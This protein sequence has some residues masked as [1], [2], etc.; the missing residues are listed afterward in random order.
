MYQTGT[1]TR[2][3]KA[4]LFLLSSFAVFCAAP[5]VF[6][7]GSDGL[8]G[9]YQDIETVEVVGQVIASSNSYT[10]T[11]I[12]FEA[13][14]SGL[15]PVAVLPELLALAP[16]ANVRTNSRGEALVSFRGAGERQFAAF[17]NGVP[18]NVPWD[19][20][21]DLRLVPLV[22]VGRTS[23]TSGPAVARL[24][25]G[26]AGGVV[27][28]QPDTRDGV[29]L[30]VEAGSG[31][32]QR[33][34][35]S[36]RGSTDASSLLL[37]VGH[38][39]RAGL[40]AES[41]SR[42]VFAAPE[43]DLITNT[44]RR[45]SNILAHVKTELSGGDTLSATLLY[46]DAVYGVA[47]EQGA[48]FTASDT[49]YWRYPKS[50]YLLASVKAEI[51]FGAKTFGEFVAW[52]Q[53][54]NQ[55]IQSFT[56]SAYRVL[57]DVQ[58]DRNNSYGVRANFRNETS[59]GVF[60][61]SGSAL[62]SR[63]REAGRPSSNSIT[64]DDIFSHTQY[65]AALDYEGQL[66]DVLTLNLGAGYDVLNP[67]ETAGRISA[68][69][70]SGVNAVAELNWAPAGGWLFRASAGRRVRLPTMREL[71]GDAIGRFLL[72][73]DLSPEQTWQ[74][75]LAA[76]WQSESASFQIVPFA[77]FTHGTLDQRRIN[78]DGQLLRQRF[79]LRGHQTFGVEAQ[80]NMQLH[81][82]LQLNGHLTWN[83]HHVLREN[84][85]NS[86]RR[87]YLSDRPNW[88]ARANAAYQLGAKTT[89]GLTVVYRG[90]AR[91]QD[92]SGNFRRVSDATQL[93]LALSHQLVEDEDGLRVALYARADNLTDAFIEPQLGLPERG[94][95][96]LF[97]LTANL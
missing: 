49:R 88:L 41:D 4:G 91:S 34:E 78:V 77:S 53:S 55:D 20:R 8:S 1:I 40:P 46:N 36:Y 38:S 79:N 75:D 73:P 14:S 66:S 47:P 61:L 51:E 2:H 37:A 26:T 95:S 69:Q 93:N 15:T 90:E 7:A 29:A 5:A 62:S 82:K 32:L 50:E 94:R 16:S 48:G 60:T 45:Q 96:F 21:I 59:G 30:L 22:G 58:E 70:F 89:F 10:G 74:V 85:D 24:G 86:T 44:D 28:L 87:L 13:P 12:T 83:V 92:G 57:E 18:L 56:D 19:N 39:D 80:G 35:G 52:Q 3:H 68:G 43:S 72:N 6:A 25:M 67:N 11:R 42:N 71:F 65:G 9:D 17:Y 23:I 31:N 33:A 27:E 81:D 64:S 54:F 97:G 63:H 84:V 76:V